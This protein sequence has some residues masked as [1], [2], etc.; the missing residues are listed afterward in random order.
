MYIYKETFITKQQLT[1]KV[2]CDLINKIG[3]DFYLVELVT[4]NNTQI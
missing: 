2:S 4:S 1:Q 3:G